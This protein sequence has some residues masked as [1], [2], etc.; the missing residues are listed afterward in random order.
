[1][2]ILLIDNKILLCYYIKRYFVLFKHQFKG[3]SCAKFKMG[4]SEWYCS[5]ARKI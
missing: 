5:G 3:G 4:K 1:M 2:S